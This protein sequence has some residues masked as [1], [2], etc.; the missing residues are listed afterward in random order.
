M[1]I[2]EVENL[3]K[4][5]QISKIEKEHTA[6]EN[7]SFS[8][9]EGEVLGILGRSSA[10]KT[11]LLRILRGVESFKEG[12]VRVDGIT[13]TPDSNSNEQLELQKITALHLQRSFALWP[14]SVINNVM[15]KLGKLETGFEEIPTTGSNDYKRLFK[16]ASEILDIVGMLDKKYYYYNILSGGEKQC[17][18]LAR[19]LAANPRVLL[20]DEPATMIDPVGRGM[21]LDAIKKINEN[22]G[23]TVVFVSH[24]PEIHETLADRVLW[25]EEGKVVD[26]GKPDE[27]IKKFVAKID[28]PVEPSIP[29]EV[30]KMRLTNLWKRYQ[31]T[32][33]GA[34]FIETIQMKNLNFDIYE[35][36]ILALVGP[37]AAGKTV[38]IRL[39]AGLEP[40]QFG[41]V[42]YRIN[43]GGEE[44]WTNICTY[45]YDAVKA[46]L[47]ISTLHQ[48]F[49]LTHYEIV[50]HLFEQKLGLKDVRFLPE[51]VE[52][53][54]EMGLS[55]VKL[56]VLYRLADLP[57]DEMKDMLRE[58]KLDPGILRKLFP[59]I[60]ADEAKKRMK[61]I[62]EALDLPLSLM[63]HY[64]YELSAGEQIRVA[65]ALHMTEKPEVLLL[66][67]PFGDLDPISLRKCIN[68]I[69][70]L[71]KEH[72]LTIILVSHQ[73]DAVK[74]LA[75]RALLIHR[76]EI[77]MT[78]DPET[79][80]N[81]FVN[82]KYA[83]FVSKGGEIEDTGDAYRYF[84]LS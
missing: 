59:T 31:I 15:R 76:G 27:I 29:R 3:T 58:L 41:E 73:L 54:R 39:L 25:I 45:G 51:V 63:D 75:H 21:M 5:Y 60:P 48:E 11:T 77:L 65:L 82:R 37:C 33:S 1:K 38:L 46:R 20:V 56:D 79:I 74:E 40:P 44:R 23:V 84:H 70:T 13:L 72:N 68:A 30:P 49:A 22:A 17:V 4:T 18:L 14:E 24:M 26:E 69:K 34:K 35:G 2:I 9:D 64:T 67:E 80:C 62:F 50:L 71:N 32:T 61:P 6:L 78:G 16:R 57:E 66:D 12:S 7:V 55:D 43:D 83:D 10:G 81:E 19:Q 47:N 36:E 52:R 28:Q 42:T 8:V 53:A